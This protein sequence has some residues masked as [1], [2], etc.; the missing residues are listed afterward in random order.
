MLRLAC[1]SLELVALDLASLKSVRECADE[2]LAKGQFFDVVI[3]M[4]AVMAHPSATRRMV[5]ETQFGT[6]HL[7]HFVA[8]QPDCASSAQRRQAHQPLFCLVIASPTL[9]LKT[10]L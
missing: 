10:Q 1:G 6:N 9:T 2:L 7:G 5:F 4:Q 3:A 8:G